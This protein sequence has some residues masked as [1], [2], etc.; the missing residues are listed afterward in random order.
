[1]ILTITPNA[2]VDKTYRID[3][4]ELDRVNRPS[5]S[6]TVAG[7]KG[8]NV[9]RVYQTLGGKAVASGFLGGLN[10]S[11]IAKSLSLESISSEFVQVDGESRVCI[12]VIDP[13]TGFQTEINESGPTI[14]ADNIADLREKV[15]TLLL[16]QSF[17]FIALCGSLPP[18]A[19]VSL[20][21]ELITLA[22]SFDVKS[23]L[24]TSG[25]PLILGLEARPWMVKPNLFELQAV[26]D[27]PLTDRSAQLA[28]VNRMHARG[29]EV[30]ALTLGSKGAIASAK[31]CGEADAIVW[32]ATPPPIEF[33]SAVA[34][35]DSFLAAFLWSWNHSDK[36]DDNSP[37]DKLERALRLGTGAGA[38]N[39]AEIGAG[40]CSRSSILSAA[41][42]AQTLRIDSINGA[43]N[44]SFT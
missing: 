2:A 18:G 33:A 8:I 12:A 36:Y 5:Q 44:G 35:G 24:D 13:T 16:E 20:F 28:A 26:F 25:E 11:V 9:A 10:G 3:G 6:L 40:F 31:L 1:M 41:E 7:G 29:V 15:R 4:F 22:R 38:A 42:R 34:S 21:A 19:P 30:V 43:R 39:A 32:Q 23:V 17:E 37:V 14:S 27:G